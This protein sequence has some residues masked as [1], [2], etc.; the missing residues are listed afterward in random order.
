[1]P[2]AARVRAHRKRRKLDQRRAKVRV[3]FAAFTWLEQHGY[4]EGPPP[5]SDQALAA[6]MERLLDDLISARRWRQQ[7]SVDRSLA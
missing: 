5:Y 1:M 2:V 4:F 7:V 6:A 3:N